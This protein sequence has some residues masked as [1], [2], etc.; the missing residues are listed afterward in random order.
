VV[1]IIHLNRHETNKH[2]YITWQRLVN[3]GI[4][5]L[6]RCIMIIGAGFGLGNGMREDTG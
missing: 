2:S 5:L 3:L 1:L 6:Q 4:V